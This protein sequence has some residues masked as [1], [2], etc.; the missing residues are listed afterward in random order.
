MKPPRPR[1]RGRR[2]GLVRTPRPPP[3]A[4]ISGNGEGCRRSAEEGFASPT[5]RSAGRS[6]DAT[7]YAL[8]EFVDSDYDEFA[9]LGSRIY[10]NHPRT[11]DNLRDRDRI[12]RS[13]GMV[14][15]RYV[16]EERASGRTVGFG[17]LTTPVFGPEPGVF[18]VFVL[19]DPDHQGRG[20]GRL[21]AETVERGAADRA[22]SSSGSSSGRISFAEWR[23]WHDGVRRTATPV[24]IASGRA[25][26]GSF[27]APRPTGRTRPRSDRRHHPSRRRGGIPT[28]VGSGFIG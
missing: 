17:D 25:R 23:F 21:L 5:L 8:R 9:H 7:R 3:C 26:S 27:R 4:G 28:E 20:I 14:L 2:L 18:W 15:R 19:V 10:P 6:V 22:R 1:A 13:P 12:F 24:G 11:A 16:A